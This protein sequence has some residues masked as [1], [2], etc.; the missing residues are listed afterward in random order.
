[1]APK[2]ARI[3]QRDPES[4]DAIRDGIKNGIVA[5]AYASL[6][7]AYGIGQAVVQ[8][9]GLLGALYDIHRRVI[10]QGFWGKDIFDGRW[11]WDNAAAKGQ[12]EQRDATADYGSRA[13]RQDQDH[14]RAADRDR[15]DELER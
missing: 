8:Q 14:I 11:H 1:M 10:E 6:G 2:N 12:G 13:E 3:F 5:R 4:A 15:G 9:S 7:N